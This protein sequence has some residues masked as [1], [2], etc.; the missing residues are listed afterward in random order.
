VDKVDKLETDPV[1]MYLMQMSEIPLLTHLQETTAAR[2][3]ERTRKKY[4]HLLLSANYI[5]QATVS[6]L[7]KVRDGGVRLERAVEVSTADARQ[8]RA[9]LGRLAPNLHTVQALLRANRADYRIAVSKRQ[10]MAHRREAWRRLVNR[11]GKA[12]R[13]VEELRLRME[14]LQPIVRNL[15]ESAQQIERL[16]QQRDA[17]EATPEEQSLAAERRS[18]TLRMMWATLET[19]AT[20]RRRI[21]RILWLQRKYETA[22]QELV[23]GNLRLVVSVARRYRNRGVSFLDLIQEGNTGLIRAADKFEHARGFRFSTYATWWIRQAITRAI[24]DVGRTIRIPVH[25]TDKMGKVQGVAQHL[26]QTMGCKP[27]LEETA[28]AAGMSFDETT[29]A[30]RMLRPPLSLDQPVDEQNANYLGEILEDHRREDPLREINRD[31][32]HSHIADALEALEYRE[33][34]ILRLR[35]G[36]SDGYPYTLSEVGRIFSVTR[37][38][39]RQIELG[40]LRKLQQP[41]HAKRLSVFL[42]Y[43]L[44][45]PVMEGIS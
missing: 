18:Q 24:A 36:L 26:S 43:P 19:P 31:S 8:K 42:D 38:R 2:R 9:L 25:M 16:Y 45:G 15:Q 4:R 39:V 10:P 21:A 41:S 32:L 3:I 22:R 33:R 11:S 27:S 17:A 7:K 34:E 30:L 6:L 1:Q 14:A 40:A 37:E 23:A 20:L 44:V 13:L 28:V 5:L 29:R 12:A 35:F